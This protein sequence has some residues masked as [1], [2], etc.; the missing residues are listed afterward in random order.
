MSVIPGRNCVL[1][2]LQCIHR[3]SEVW[4]EKAHRQFICTSHHLIHDLQMHD[5]II[6]YQWKTSYRMF[7]EKKNDTFHILVPGHVINPTSFA[8]KQQLSRNV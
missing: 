6:F 1:V 5:F 4:G 8:E 7:T 3:E 2:A